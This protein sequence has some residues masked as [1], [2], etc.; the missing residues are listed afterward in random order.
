MPAMRSLGVV[1]RLMDSGFSGFDYPNTG[2]LTQ[3]LSSSSSE[4]NAV[5]Q[6]G[7]WGFR[8]ATLDAYVDEADALI[9]RA[10]YEGRTEVAFVDL[11]SSVSFVRIFAFERHM[12]FSGLW[13]AT[14]TLLETPEAAGS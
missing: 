14:M 2:Q 7:G 5:L 8:Q 1:T 3:L 11:D 10:Y 4:G 13:Q 9:L 12:V 6:D